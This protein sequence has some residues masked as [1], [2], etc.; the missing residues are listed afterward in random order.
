[1]VAFTFVRGN[2]NLN[3]LPDKALMNSQ[4]LELSKLVKIEQTQPN[5]LGLP[6]GDIKVITP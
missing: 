2:V 1:M 3:N 4:V 6:Q 5:T